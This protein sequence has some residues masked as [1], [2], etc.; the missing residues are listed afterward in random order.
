MFKSLDLNALITCSLM[1]ICF[2]KH[3]MIGIIYLIASISLSGM[4]EIVDM[5][6]GI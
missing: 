2:S 3:V 4:I 1:Y 6:F 5:A